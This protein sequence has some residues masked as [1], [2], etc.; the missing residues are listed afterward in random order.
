MTSILP[1]ELYRTQPFS[2]YLLW[3][4]QPHLLWLEERQSFIKKLLGKLLT[5]SRLLCWRRIDGTGGNPKI[6]RREKGS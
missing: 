4:L 2:S 3:T 6:T 1:V 5:P